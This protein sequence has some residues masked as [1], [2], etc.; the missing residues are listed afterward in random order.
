MDLQILESRFNRRPHSPLFARIAEEY[1]IAG[2]LDE[3]KR[4]CF[5]GIENYPEYVSGR[6]LLAKCFVAEGNL[7][8]AGRI[9]ERVR[10]QYPRSTV[11]KNLLVEWS[12]QAFVPAVEEADGAGTFD[13]RPESDDIG[14][15]EETFDSAADLIADPILPAVESE[16]NPFPIDSV[17]II[18]IPDA[19]IDL[20]D[21]LPAHSAVTDEQFSRPAAPQDDLAIAQ[22]LIDDG[23]DV[24]TVMPETPAHLVDQVLPERSA[25]EVQAESSE[26]EGDYFRSMLE[27][28]DEESADRLQDVD[29]AGPVN[30]EDRVP[31]G[32]RP[33][34]RVSENAGVGTGLPD[35]SGPVGVQFTS[36]LDAMVAGVETHTVIDVALALPDELDEAGMVDETMVSVPVAAGEQKDSQTI[37]DAGVDQ[38]VLE[39]IVEPPAATVPGA[40]AHEV[41]VIVIGK[42]E[43]ASPEER[44]GEEGD[45]TSTERVVPASE[46]VPA[47]TGVQE[48]AFIPPEFQQDG[49]IESRGTRNVRSQPADS[50]DDEE[51][52]I[53]S[54]TLAQIYESQG[55]YEEALTTYRLLRKR[56]PELAAQLDAKIAELAALIEARLTQ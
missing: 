3:A 13:S 23:H 22:D 21:V 1:L 12:T 32:V 54:R 16:V 24:T 41:P 15:V 9:I 53:V 40:A 34:D 46:A 19:P 5:A 44:G 36:I 37:Q 47:A 31:E 48:D 18:R 20:P 56:R 11:L 29:I 33:D 49:G 43:P 4:L 51:S 38:G 6:L 30:A 27:D 25:L 45:D 39:T 7:E 10:E 2:R 52:R 8:E 28:V 55:E 35:S 50:V 17:E 42:Q 14:E 26:N